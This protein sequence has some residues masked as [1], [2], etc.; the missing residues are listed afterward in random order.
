M[1]M[2]HLHKGVLTGMV[3]CGAMIA[4]DAQALIAVVTNGNNAGAGSLRRA[5]ADANNNPLVTAIEIEPTVGDIV[6]SSRLTYTGTQPLVI[7]ASGSTVITDGVYAGDLFL[8]TR[9]KSLTLAGLSF[10]GGANGII[11]RLPSTTTGLAT[12]DIDDAFIGGGTGHAVYVDDLLTPTT[13]SAASVEVGIVGCLIAG[14]LL[15]GVRVDER[16][17]GSAFLTI[18]NSLIDGCGGNGATVSEAGTGLAEVVVRSS[19]IV[20]NGG[21]GVSASEADGGILAFLLREG[22]FIGFNTGDQVHLSELGGG[23]LEAELREFSTIDVGGSVNDAIEASQVA[24]G[25][26]SLAI[27]ETSSVSGPVTLTGVDIVP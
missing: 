17:G 20:N 27:D 21:D 15:D 16:G 4:S 8:S 13:G 2:G 25:L 19:T 10:F 12:L 22:S 24:P 23:A 6:I 11:F 3:A 5:I 1:K 7:E 9:T 18:R 14:S 26:G